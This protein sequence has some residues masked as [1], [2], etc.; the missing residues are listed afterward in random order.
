MLEDAL[1]RFWLRFDENKHFI[2]LNNL[3]KNSPGD[4]ATFVIYSTAV[5]KI[6]CLALI[7]FTRNAQLKV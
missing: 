5:C 3:F 7:K 4:R 6:S 1:Y 2:I